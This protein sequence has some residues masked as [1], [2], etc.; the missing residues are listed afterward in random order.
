MT[1]RK[2]LNT[3]VDEE[4]I[5]DFREFTH[6]KKGKIRGE[7]G[8][9]VEKAMIEYMD[10]DRQQ[11]LED[12][13]ERLESKVDTILSTLSDSGG[14]HTHMAH[15]QPKT[16]SEKAETIAA[17]LKDSTDMVVPVADVEAEIKDV[18]GSDDRTLSQYKDE[19]KEL[20][21]VFAHPAPS[22]KVWTTDRET[23]VGWVENH[24]DNVPDSDIHDILEDYKM[25]LQEYERMTTPEATA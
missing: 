8:R 7:M 14:T 16:V 4:V 24:L 2:P 22:S 5:K 13:H 17:R 12:D 21:G 11:R 9:L 19:L 10:N 18:A 6:D 25:S 23:W 3:R 20:G 15:A 1:Q